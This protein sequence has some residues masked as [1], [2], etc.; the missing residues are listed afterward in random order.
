MLDQLQHYFF[1]PVSGVLLS[2]TFFYAWLMF[3][4]DRECVIRT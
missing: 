3:D 1:F 4:K 2:Y